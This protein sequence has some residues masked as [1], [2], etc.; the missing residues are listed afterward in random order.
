MQHR[1]TPVE[2]SQSIHATSNDAK[3]NISTR[4]M[5]HRKT[6][7]RNPSTGATTEDGI[8]LATGGTVARTMADGGN[9][10]PPSGNGRARPQP[11]GRRTAG[12]P[13]AAGTGGVS[14]TASCLPPAESGGSGARV[15]FGREWVVGVWIQQQRGRTA[16]R[17]VDQGRG[18]PQGLRGMWVDQG[19]GWPPDSPAGGQGKPGSSHCG[20][21]GER[22]ERCGENEWRGTKHV[23][24]RNP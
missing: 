21:K 22:S 1:T 15:G 20:E 5:Q 19:R 13:S 14:G 18:W 2:T 9:S 8:T 3:W 12:I 7:T 6:Q 10:P 4:F 23:V 17:Q 24:W 16:R 11:R